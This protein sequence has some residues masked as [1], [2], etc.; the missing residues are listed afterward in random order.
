MYRKLANSLTHF[1]VKKKVVSEDEVEAYAY[2]FEILLSIIVYE[3]IFVLIS[4]FTNTFIPS[5]GFWISFFFIRTFCGGFH[6]STYFKCHLM[7]LANHVL[8]IFLYKH[9]FLLIDHKW[10][11]VF[12]FFSALTV[13]LI[14]P[15]DHPNKP[16]LENEYSKFK[17]RS[18]TYGVLIIILA[19]FNIFFS[20]KDFGWGYGFGTLSATISLI[21]AKI[22]YKKR[23][24]I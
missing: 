18:R 5:L 23:K 15:V 3:S 2:G 10:V 17:K 11:S 22:L 4:I 14:A 24:E 6:A 16:F 9:L 19:V 13:F 21:F 20:T 7:F 12:L 8:F 1:F